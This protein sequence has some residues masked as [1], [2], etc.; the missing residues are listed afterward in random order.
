MWRY[1]GDDHEFWTILSTEFT[2]FTGIKIDTYRSMNCFQKVSFFQENRLAFEL[3]GV[4]KWLFPK[5]TKK[6]VF[7]PP[8]V[9]DHVVTQTC[10]TV[11]AHFFDFPIDFFWGLPPSLYADQVLRAAFRAAPTPPYSIR[12]AQN[13]QNGETLYKWTKRTFVWNGSAKVELWCRR[14]LNFHVFYYF[15][16]NKHAKQMS[17]KIAKIELSFEPELNFCNFGG[18]QNEPPKALW[19]PT[20]LHHFS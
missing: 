12:V 3:E 13:S 14:E 8:L 2:G 4:K 11:R 6:K 7:F 16:Q 19:T 1:T 5:E 20:W 10:I 17:S 15:S 18:L 9:S